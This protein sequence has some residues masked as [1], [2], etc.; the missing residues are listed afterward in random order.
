MKKY[1]DDICRLTNC[2]NL[3]VC[4]GLCG[5]LRDVVNGK[6][7]AK[8]ILM[9]NLVEPEKIEYKDYKETL[10]ELAEDM[11]IREEQRKEK[12]LCLINSPH[13]RDNLIKFAIVAGYD[14]KELSKYYSLS[15]QQIYKIIKKTGE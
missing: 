2:V 8:E 9:S 13:D 15:L 3:D 14:P 5:F 10:S 7:K 1:R 6:N 11:E 12:L 4:L